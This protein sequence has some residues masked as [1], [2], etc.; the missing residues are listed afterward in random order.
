MF[1]GV[2][3]RLVLSQITPIWVGP[4]EPAHFTF[5]KHL[6]ETWQL[7]ELKP[8]AEV[9]NTTWYSTIQQP[10][11]F[12]ALLVPFYRGISSLSVDSLVHILRLLSVLIGAVHVFLVY[13]LAKEIT[14]REDFAL[15][16]AAFVSF[17]PT[18]IVVS[19]VIN[20]GPLVWVFVTASALFMVYSIKNNYN[21]MQACLGALFFGLSVFTKYTA[22]SLLISF[23]I[24]W[25]CFFKKSQSSIG[26]KFFL[27]VFPFFIFGPIFLR[28]FFVYGAFIPTQEVSITKL[29]ISWLVYYIIH[30]F[31]GYWVQEYGTAYI[32]DIRYFFF[33]VFGVFSLVSL[34]GLIFFLLKRKTKLLELVRSSKFFDNKKAVYYSIILSGLFLNFAGLTWLNTKW[35]FP[36]ARLMF[37]TLSFFALLFVLG[38]FHFWS[39]LGKQ[40]LFKPSLYIL[41]ACLLFFDLIL[42]VNHNSVLPKVP[43]PLL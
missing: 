20:N 39:G 15:L 34:V 21:F 12:Y 18:H 30:L 25:I 36:D 33:A 27:L 2:A 11:F 5:I 37:E 43:W 14:T 6:S 41:L 1:I 3:F 8:T 22:L 17:L 23:L 42:L 38:T 19:S 35:L 24:F 29:D 10:P 26:K 40:K 7:T 4:D 13:K 31:P 32:P 28:N 9:L 16:S